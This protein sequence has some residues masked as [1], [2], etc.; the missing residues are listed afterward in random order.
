MKLIIQ[1]PAFN[2]E[3]TLPQVL[4]E[5][6]HSIVGVDQIQILVIDDGST[7]RTAEVAV[8]SG[9]H[10]VVRHVSNRG[11][12]AAF[13]TG[14]DAALRL[15]ADIIVN[16]DADN[17]YPGDQIAQLVA[18]IV[19]RRAD[20]VI[21]DRQTHTL[22][23]FSRRKRAL[24]RLGSWVVQQASGIEALDSVSGFRA[25]SCEA[26]L[27]LFVTTDF[28]YT[29]EH[30][31]QAGKR[32]LVVAHVPIRVNPTRASRLHRGNWNFVKRQAATIVRTY[33]TYEP[34]RTFT[35][36]AMPFLIFGFGFL[37][38]AVYVFVGRRLGITGGDNLQ[39][40]TLGTGLV[41]LGFVIFLIGLV[42]DRIG[43][44]RRLME[45]VLYR[46]RRRELDHLEWQRTVAA[47]F[48][49][50]DATQRTGVLVGRAS[51]ADEGNDRL[52][53]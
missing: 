17:Q 5:L 20:I 44:N 14:M 11:L 15:G 9:A 2:E 35:Y 26:A 39:A 45:E 48:D 19:E 43:S 47:R 24:Q 33:A 10:H 53:R 30:V 34:L 38:R 7:D 40:L 49:E 22:P 36:I 42:A 3:D 32:R 31:I 18:P 8:A 1:I 4:R 41:V 27:R 52:P 16:T 21:G 29:V 13:Q 28:S 25:L 37:L 23:H 46:M 6:P 12:A 51:D 50:L